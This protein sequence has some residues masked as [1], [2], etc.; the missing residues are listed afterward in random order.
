MNFNELNVHKSCF[1]VHTYNSFLKKST[2][3]YSSAVVRAVSPE[4]IGRGIYCFT[5]VIFIRKS[6]LPC[7]TI[8]P[9]NLHL[10]YKCFLFFNLPNVEQTGYISRKLNQSRIVCCYF[11]SFT[12]LGCV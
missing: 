8:S 3:Q 7:L 1:S 4:E 12:C 11:L 10:I 2:L 5:H 9:L 6:K